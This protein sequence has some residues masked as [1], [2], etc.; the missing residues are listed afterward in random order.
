MDL[1]YKIE[2]KSTFLSYSMSTAIL[3]GRKPTL[4]LY[5]TISF[6]RTKAGVWY[7]T[8]IWKYWHLI[9]NDLTFQGVY[10][11]EKPLNPWLL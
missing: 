6:E 10:L 8:T 7:E 2:T 3:D 9:K 4:Q 5:S 11:H 1:H